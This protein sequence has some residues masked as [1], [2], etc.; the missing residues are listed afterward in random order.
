M[1]EANDSEMAP[2]TSPP[3][4]NHSHPPLPVIPTSHRGFFPSDRLNISGA[5]PSLSWCRWSAAEARIVTAIYINNL[6]TVNT[7][8]LPLYAAV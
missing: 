1:R 6:A 8:S 7:N 5:S 4:P 2:P 3:P